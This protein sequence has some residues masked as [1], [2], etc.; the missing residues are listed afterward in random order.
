MAY[1]NL[2]TFD[3]FELVN[4]PKT[5]RK[6][7]EAKEVIQATEDSLLQTYIFLLQNL[8]LQAEVK[9]LWVTKTVVSEDTM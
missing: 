7:R 8:I 4:K 2:Y 6:I 3:S 1:C 5:G 9:E